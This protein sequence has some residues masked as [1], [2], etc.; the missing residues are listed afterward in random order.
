MPGK[1]WQFGGT[2]DHARE[3]MAVRGTADHARKG[4]EVR[5]YSPPCQERHVSGSLRQLV[6][7]QPQLGGSMKTW[8]SH[9]F[10]FYLVLAPS[11]QK[12]SM[13]RWGLSLHL[14]Y[15]KVN[16][17]LQTQPEVT[18]KTSLLPLNIVP[19]PKPHPRTQCL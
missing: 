5:G 9:A 13:H 14:S 3:G 19:H 2:A 6:A 16:T 17:S 7:L 1:T 4:M 12:A 18:I 8:S 15:S 10:S 11:R